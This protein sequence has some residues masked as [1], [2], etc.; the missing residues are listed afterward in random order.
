MTVHCALQAV[1]DGHAMNKTLTLFSHMFTGT[2]VRVD[3]R[4]TVRPD[5][6]VS[7]LAQVALTPDASA[8]AALERLVVHL[9]REPGVRNV[10]WHLHTKNTPSAPPR[11]PGPDDEKPSQ[12]TA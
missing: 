9:T 3:S 5:G 12:G 10:R 2:G 7:V 6:R 1:C 11:P 4:C 8:T